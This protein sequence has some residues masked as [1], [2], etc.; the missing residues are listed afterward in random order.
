MR[1]IQRL[2][3]LNDSECFIHA[4]SVSLFWHCDHALLTGSR[5]CFKASSL[6]IFVLRGLSVLSAIYPASWWGVGVGSIGSI[7]IVTAR[8]DVWP[9]REIVAT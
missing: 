7:G 4:L 6:T 2:S 1:T 9:H 5:A 3:G 8:G